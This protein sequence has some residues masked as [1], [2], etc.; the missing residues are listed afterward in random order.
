MKCICKFSSITTTV[1]NNGTNSLKNCKQ[2]EGIK[3]YYKY[4][5]EEMYLRNNFHKILLLQNTIR[6]TINNYYCILVDV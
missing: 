5:Y 2:E 6:A 3:G 1:C 4:E